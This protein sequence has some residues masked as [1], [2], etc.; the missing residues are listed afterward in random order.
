MDDLY[1]GRIQGGGLVPPPHILVEKQYNSLDNTISPLH[2]PLIDMCVTPS[3]SM[4]AGSGP[5]YGK[6]LLQ[7]Y[8]SFTF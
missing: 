2:Y 3:L 6:N 4:R 1:H 5:V 8:I 7:V